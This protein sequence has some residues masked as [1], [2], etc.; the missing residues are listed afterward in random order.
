MI[1]LADDVLD[2]VASDNEPKGW[3]TMTRAGIL[4][5]IPEKIV[6]ATIR[7]LFYDRPV[8]SF[9]SGKEIRTVEY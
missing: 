6:P 3:P 4:P 2:S 7:S 5:A 8:E 1:N 9:E